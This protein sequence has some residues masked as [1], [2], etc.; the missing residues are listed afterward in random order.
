MHTTPEFPDLLRLIDERAEAFRAAA[1]SAPDLNAQVPTCPDWTLR[2]LIQHLGSVHR[3]W[4][5]VV[6]TGPAD[7]QP[8][9]EDDIEAGPRN[10][11][12]L[13]AWS[14]DSTALLL[15]KL[16]EAGPNSGCWTWWEAWQAP[17]TA[18]AVARHQVQEAA[19][20]TYDA[21]NITK[22]QPLPPETAVDGVEEF[23][24]TCCTTTSPWPH[25]PATI[26][27]HVTE[28]TWR[29]TLSG[30]G[31]HVSTLPT[32]KA[33]VSTRSTAGE[34]V[35]ALY[36]RLPFDALTIDGDRRIL[37]QLKDWEPDD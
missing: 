6:A 34:L 5:G 20:H 4:A 15:Q 11:D 27:F 21:Q 9:Q 23:L 36:G 33:T 3:F 17:Q 29:L 24:T 25:H 37:D 13:L 30:D 22:A 7:T 31:A 1:S 12:A 2:D 26:D 8:I 35:L 14:A 10:R 18:A 16:H 28:G 32:D 19:V